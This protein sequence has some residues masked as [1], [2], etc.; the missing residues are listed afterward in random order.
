MLLPSERVF[1]NDTILSLGTGDA[2]SGHLL[3]TS[4]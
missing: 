3:H 1:G 4:S 2:L